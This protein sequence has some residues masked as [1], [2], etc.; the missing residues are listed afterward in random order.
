[1]GHTAYSIPF[2]S[3]WDKYQSSNLTDSFENLD[4]I[5]D[6]PFRV[7]I[8]IC[9]VGVCNTPIEG[10]YGRT[11]EYEVQFCM[12]ANQVNPKTHFLTSPTSTM[13]T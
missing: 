12:Y 3:L 6:C 9:G 11:I 7:C 5:Q 4:I 1:M 10:A 8:F 13:L 2:L